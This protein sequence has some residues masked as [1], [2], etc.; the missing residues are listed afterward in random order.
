LDLGQLNQEKASL[1]EDW[2][3]TMGEIEALQQPLVTTD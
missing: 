2:L 1:E 3:R